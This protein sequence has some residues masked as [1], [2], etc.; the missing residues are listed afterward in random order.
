MIRKH[1]IWNEAQGTLD[2]SFPPTH[3][4]HSASSNQL[5]GEL[6]TTLDSLERK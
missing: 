4:H 3:N 2:D 5:H 6:H 1:N